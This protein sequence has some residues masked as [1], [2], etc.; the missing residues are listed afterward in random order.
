MKSYVDNIDPLW[1]DEE[2]NLPLWYLPS[3]TWNHSQIMRTGFPWWLSGKESTCQ[4]GDS[5]LIP[6]LGRYP[7]EGDV[8]MTEKACSFA[9]A[10][11][12]CWS[13]HLSKVLILLLVLAGRVPWQMIPTIKRA[14]NLF[15]LAQYPLS[16]LMLLQMAR[17][18]SFYGRVIF[19]CIYVPHIFYPFICW[20]TVML[21]P[22][23]GC[24][25]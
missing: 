20:W 18:H 19:H 17:F 12:C 7:R 1:C 10:K 5:G 15:Y 24:C 6:G 22:Y 23:L 8:D 21:L 9:W 11:W 13:G 4:A 2:S 25:K 3:G 16:L 14:R